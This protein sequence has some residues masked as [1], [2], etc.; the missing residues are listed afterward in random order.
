M[1]TFSTQGKGNSSADITSAKARNIAQIS[2]EYDVSDQTKST[3]MQFSRYALEYG[4]A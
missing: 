2:A 1:T 4:L 3:L